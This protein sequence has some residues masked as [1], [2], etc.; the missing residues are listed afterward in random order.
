MQL[1]HKRLFKDHDGN[2]EIRRY[3]ADL[4]MNTV[5][6]T[7]L[8]ATGKACPYNRV[9][10]K[11]SSGRGQKLLDRVPLSCFFFLLLWFMV[12]SGS[13]TGARWKVLLSFFP[14]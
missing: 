12:Y 14:P 8:K 10:N 7:C 6:L 3:Q 13:E 5:F 1:Y 4:D 11:G 9:A 2:I